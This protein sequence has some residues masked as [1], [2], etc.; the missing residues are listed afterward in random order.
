MTL[1][2]TSYGEKLTTLPVLIRCQYFLLH[3]HKASVCIILKTE[4]AVAVINILLLSEIKANTSMVA[5]LELMI[6]I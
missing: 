3:F 6:P 2:I 4:T 5:R 1:E